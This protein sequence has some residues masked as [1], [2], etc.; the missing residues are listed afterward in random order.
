MSVD[1]GRDVEASMVANVN[2]QRPPSPIAWA[3]RGIVVDAS[4]TAGPKTFNYP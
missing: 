2:D 3:R 4:M 1:R